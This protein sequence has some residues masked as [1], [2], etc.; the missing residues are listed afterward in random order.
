[1]VRLEI[2]LLGAGMMGSVHSQAWLQV[3]DARV[4]WVFDQD[5][6]RAA[7]VA[8]TLGARPT[9]QLDEIL[10]DPTV[11]A[12]DI[13]LPTDLHRPFTEAAAAAG[14]HVFC[15]KPIARTLADAQAMVEACHRAGVQLMVGHVLRFF[16]EYTAARDVV[17]SGRIGEPKVIRATRAGA[18]P[19]WGA[20]NWFADRARSGGPILDLMIHDIDYIR[21][22][23]GPV[24]RVYAQEQGNYALVT[25]RLE[26]GAIAHVEGSWAHPPGTPFTTKL[27]IA[28]TEGL[29][30]TS[31]QAGIPL[32]VRRVV[33]G[34]PAY[35]PE[36]PPPADP[37]AVE[38]Q[39]FAA[40]VKAGE[41]PPVSGEAAIESLRVCLAA[42]SS[43][44]EGIPVELGGTGS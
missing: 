26:S 11:E 39:L 30:A 31:N 23:F 42:I 3:A 13:A 34:E 15:E 6:G 27:E 14:K 41:R 18:F 43:A 25:L 37:Y 32:A 40:A 22:C 5:P 20:E 29:Y 7:R 12:V 35:E 24:R 8:E 38:L 21:W 1:M 28:G 17:Q 10:S 2:A 33:D 44:E 19:T 4:R 16:A 36:S 9:T